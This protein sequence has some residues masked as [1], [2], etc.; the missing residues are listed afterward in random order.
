MHDSCI[1]L[2]MRLHLL[3]RREESDPQ[4]PRDRFHGPHLATHPI[5]F[6][7]HQ[8]HGRLRFWVGGRL[9]FDRPSRQGCWYL[10]APGTRHASLIP[11]RQRHRV[12]WT[13][14]EEATVWLAVFYR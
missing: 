11:A 1:Y 3:G 4:P 2:Q 6:Y 5:L 7:I 13:T 10:L 9:R 14:S 12:Q 8:V